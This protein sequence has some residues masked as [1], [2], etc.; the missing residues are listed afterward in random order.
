MVFLSKSK[1]PLYSSLSSPN[2]YNNILPNND[3]LRQSLLPISLHY[4]QFQVIGI[5]HYEKNRH[6]I[7]MNH[8]E[9]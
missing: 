3:V 1:E 4:M 6:D 8:I 9:W 5:I 7:G 2:V